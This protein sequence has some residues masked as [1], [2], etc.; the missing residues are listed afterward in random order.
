[1]PL[2]STSEQISDICNP[3]VPYSLMRKQTVPAG[4]RQPSHRP[5]C[6]FG[7]PKL[8][9]CG[10]CGYTESKG[11]LITSCSPIERSLPEV[12]KADILYGPLAPLH[13][14]SGKVKL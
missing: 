6:S 2:M 4:V 7:A 9:H 14:H 3:R 5:A 1:M 10:V 12:P 13:P 11:L 8:Y